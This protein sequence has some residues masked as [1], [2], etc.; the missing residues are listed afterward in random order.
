MRAKQQIR[1]RSRIRYWLD[2]E[3]VQAD[4]HAR[5]QSHDWGAVGA[6]VQ[7]TSCA[8]MPAPAASP[9][10]VPEPNS[11]PLT[12]TSVTDHPIPEHPLPVH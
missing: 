2:V 10:P 3:V 8:A 7:E 1:Y 4:K 5:L 12:Q 9:K 6:A 11:E